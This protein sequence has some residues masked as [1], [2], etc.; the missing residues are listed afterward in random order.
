MAY[1]G[2]VRFGF[3]QSVVK[4][5]MR[6]FLFSL[7]AISLSFV[8]PAL[9]QCPS[10][11]N[12]QQTK[13]A[14]ISGPLATNGG[15]TAVV[16]LHQNCL[17]TQYEVPGS[18][19][20]SDLKSRWYD[21]SDLR[22]PKITIFDAPANS[23][24]GAHGY[25]QEGA[26][27]RGFNDWTFSGT[28][29]QR[30]TGL[31]P[32]YY[33]PNTSGHVWP[34]RGLMF[35]PFHMSTYWSYNSTSHPVGLY[36][37]NQ[38]LSEFNPVTETGVI[39][40]PFLIGNYLYYL[41]DQ[42]QTGIAVYDIA[43]S[44]AA[45]GTKPQLVGVFKAPVDPAVPGKSVGGY[46]PEVWSGGG[47]LK[48]VFPNR[49]LGIYVVDMTDPRNMFLDFQH[50]EPY[51]HPWQSNPDASYVQ[52][53]DE[54]AFTDKFKINMLT[55]QVEKVI[56]PYA[57]GIVVSQFSLPIGNLLVTGGYYYG[58]DMPNSQAT[59]IWAHQA[60]PD[61]RSPTVG[62]HRPL[63]GQTNYPAGAPIS[64]L[65][66]ETLKSETIRNGTTLLVRPVTNGVLGAFIPGRVVYAF[67][68]VITFTPYS[69]LPANTTFQVD[70]T[71]GIQDAVGNPL[72][73]YNYRFSTG[74][75]IINPSPAAITSLTVSANPASVN[76]S[77]TVSFAST[78][79]TGVQYKVNFGDGTPETAWSSAASVAHSYTREGHFDIVLSAR[80]S[81]NSATRSTGLTILS[82][83][84]QPS[85]RH[86]S[87]SVAYS[88]ASNLSWVV[89]PDND[90]VSR[91]DASNNRLE[92]ALGNGCGPRGVDV[93]S[94]GTAWVTCHKNDSL[95][96]ISSSG[97]NLG[98]LGLPYGSAPHDIV[99]L[100]D[101]SAA[102]VTLFG[103]G[104]AVLIST[105]TK[106]I[107]STI[108]LGPTPRA[109]AL[110]ADGLNAYVTRF[111]SAD[112]GA[113]VWQLGTKPLQ[114]LRTFTIPVDTTTPDT[115]ASGKGVLNYLSGI[116]I[117][118]K[119]NRAWIVGKL[120]NIVRGQF[121]NGQ[122]LNGENT[123]RAV[124]AQID[125]NSLAYAPQARIDIDNSALPSGITFSPFG[126]YAFVSLQ[127]NNIVAV[128]DTLQQNPTVG[129]NI[130]VILRIEVGRAPF[131][132]RLAAQTKQLIVNN[133]LSRSI[134][135]VPLDTFFAGTSKN[136][137]A[138]VV[139]S[140]A[141]ERLPAQVLEGKK[142][143]YN[144][145]DNGG[146]GGV[147]RMNSEGYLSCATCHF[148]GGH[149]G[150]TW[151]FT[152]RG[153]GVRN[154]ID[155]RGRGGMGHGLVHWS[156]NFDEIQDFENDIRRSFGGIG[157]LSNAN[158]TNTANPLGTRKTGLSPELDA[159]A[160]YVASLN[161]TFTPRSPYR[162]PDG[163]KTPAAVRG[164]STFVASNCTT[165]HRMTK[166]TDSTQPTPTL[167]NVG[168]FQPESGNRLGQ[169]LT[170]LDT[171]TL[172]GLH[173]S[174]PYGHLGKANTLEEFF[175]NQT[176]APHSTV[177]T[178][179]AA[180]RSDL[181][182][183]LLELDG[184]DLSGEDNLA[185]GAPK[186]FRAN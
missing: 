173:A 56:N 58:T 148:E 120:D 163:K 61:R 124:I 100:P 171:P 96:F 12:V 99:L 57:H 162:A 167:H 176:S 175:A 172:A 89:N 72:T 20:N 8:S 116:A 139:A 152:D 50:Y 186:G 130:P 34:N 65:I 92:A 9:A 183:F 164:A 82:S 46:W 84:T 47:R 150:R 104:K 30:A 111:I 143:F 178:L 10:F 67:D 134:S 76:Q 77:V 110:S 13:G 158:F 85:A 153:E 115:T 53:Q 151:D 19:A 141:T 5:V 38:L 25:W 3:C 26:V 39:G 7:I 133:F 126:D 103:S 54:Y 24:I 68:D 45:P 59:A 31:D 36:K 4:G 28:T 159:L 127:G 184:S 6:F 51:T 22:N 75:T 181:I 119:T 121:R 108:D 140:T 149:D 32:V 18:A 60:E 160:A 118:P 83:T 90:T 14:L 17:I 48:A 62:H 70:L 109:I 55:K 73:P 43:P 142:I 105:A 101:N 125:L 166:Y 137:T 29:I 170:G 86:H 122:A 37:A 11:P 185:P 117:N 40:H 155:L 69:P 131:G 114:K 147:N 102:L 146:P 179:S 35:Q 154:N 113:E 161:E 174:A 112:G 156:G 81:V 23:I 138:S 91:F 177:N 106:Q 42:S 135:R 136:P 87:S 157:F 123:V 71:S 78:G 97:Q 2:G 41:A 145:S 93:D 64:I 27:I 128:F 182:R 52:F 95:V 165:C 1:S 107:S 88:A 129:G 66:H 16:A 94:A 98:T 33:P 132:L 15:R 74:N 44:L 80:D 49:N 180:A 63:S 169:A 144:A 21:I 79:F 168:T